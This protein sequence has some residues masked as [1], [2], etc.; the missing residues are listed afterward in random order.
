MTVKEVRR[1]YAEKFDNVSDVIKERIKHASDKSIITAD[2]VEIPGGQV[3]AF[4]FRFG[5]IQKGSAHRHSR[6]FHGLNVT[7]VLNRDVS[8]WQEAGLF[9]SETLYVVESI[10]TAD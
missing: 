9:D 1:A 2:H 8:P 7:A 3:F 6:R 10:G 4:K 5:V